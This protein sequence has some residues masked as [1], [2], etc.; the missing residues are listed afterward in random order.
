MPVWATQ[1]SVGCESRRGTPSCPRA[2]RLSSRLNAVPTSKER[3]VAQT[4][5]NSRISGNWCDK[6]D[7]PL[8][9]R[10]NSDQP[11]FLPVGTAT[12]RRRH[13]ALPAAA[14]SKYRGPFRL[15][16][17]SAPRRKG[18][19]GTRRCDTQA[20]GCARLL[21]ARVVQTS[22]RPSAGPPAPAFLAPPLLSPPRSP[23]RPPCG[24]AG[25]SGGAAGSHRALSAPHCLPPHLPPRPTRR[26]PHTLPPHLPLRP[27]ASPT[28]PPAQLST[29]PRRSS[30]PP[31][32]FQ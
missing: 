11:S 17:N 28:A 2:C 18:S 8:R 32:P 20:G 27:T 15:L 31:A 14:A 24:A 16:A 10:R 12:N 23:T 26:C 5:C 1:L 29:L 7:Q 21:A 30:R 4:A 25:R 22:R 9:Q 3:L 19:S 6:G 13:F